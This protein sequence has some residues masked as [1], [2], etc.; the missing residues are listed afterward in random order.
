MA[1]LPSGKLSH[2]LNSADFSALSARQVDHRK[3]FHLSSTVASLLVSSH[4]CL[5]HFLR[6]AERRAV[7]LRQLRLQVAAWRSGS[8]V[9][10]DLRG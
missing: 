1:V 4:L 9:G 6:D 8:V 2:T 3:C 5:Q 7:R 10:L